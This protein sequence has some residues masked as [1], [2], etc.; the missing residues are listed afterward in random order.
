MT[1][2]QP[3]DTKEKTGHTGF[4]ASLTRGPFLYITTPEENG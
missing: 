1:L 4:C 3:L 2:I